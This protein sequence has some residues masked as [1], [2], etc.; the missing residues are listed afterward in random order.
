MNREDRTLLDLAKMIQ[1]GILFLV[2]SLIAWWITGEI[3]WW[4]ATAP[5]WSAFLFT[6]T[7][8]NYYGNGVKKTP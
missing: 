6:I 7:T 5:L 8:T 1:C 3:Y 4:V 2:A